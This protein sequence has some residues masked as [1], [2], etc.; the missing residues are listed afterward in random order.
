MKDTLHPLAY[1]S[2]VAGVGKI[3]S[4]TNHLLT[5]TRNDKGKL[6]S[7]H[8]P[9]V[10]CI[11]KGKAHKKYEF[12]CKVSL[13]ITHKKGT[14]IITSANALQG[15]PYDG[16]TLRD[17]LSLSHAVSG[18]KVAK[19]FVDKGYK[20]HGISDCSVFISGQRR[21]VT[22]AIKKQMK[23]RQAIEPCI[24]HLKTEGK[25]GRRMLKGIVGDQAN[26][27]LC[28]AGYNLLR[29]LAHLRDLFA[30]IGQTVF[31]AIQFMQRAFNHTGTTILLN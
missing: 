28:A 27:L 25:L 15:N 14:G 22:A 23:H 10:A 30:P 5:R 26:A 16:H 1:A 18:I 13:S 11:S 19:V 9:D 3:L 17:T 6:Y 4:Q 20:G 2:G 8:E 29:I 24:G 7:L 12:G 31:L 21:G